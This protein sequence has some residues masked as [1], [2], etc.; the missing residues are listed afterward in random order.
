MADDI[1]PLPDLTQTTIVNGKVV[2]PNGPKARYTNDGNTKGNPQQPALALSVVKD[3]S[4]GVAN[5]NLTHVCDFVTDIQKYINL[6]RYTKSIAQEIRKAIRA[7]L[8]ALGFSD[9]TGE[10][11]LVISTLKFI[12]TEVDYI[13]KQIL[14]PILDFQQYAVAYIAKLR[15]VLQW[16]QSLPAKFLAM[17]QDCLAR[18]VKLISSVFT[19]IG[20]GLSEGFSDNE[21]DANE[22]SNII[23]AS[24]ELTNSVST[25]INS[26]I[27]VV[28]GTV[29]V[30][31]GAT[32]GLLT[33]TS[34]EELKA[35][36]AI[37][38][39]YESKDNLQ[40]YNRSQP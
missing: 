36:D 2:E 35:A 7:V 8:K 27:K 22:F 11:S 14:Q 31:G 32:L 25:T 19:D 10:A 13:N 16:I 15:S 38:A 4:V 30:V 24:K 9:A 18:I 20:A 37:I 29:N 6:K 12:K 26:S 28:A 3:T 34:Q 17:L 23:K 39:N 1:H 5:D 21:L 33:P 40:T